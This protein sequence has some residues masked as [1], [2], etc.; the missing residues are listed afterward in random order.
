MPTP[1]DIARLQAAGRVVLGGAL[2]VAPR[3][4][5]SAWLGPRDAHR[6]TTAVVASAMGARDLGIG[7]GTA[8]AV[9]AGFGARP[10][11]IAGIL[12]DVADMVATLR[13]RDD[14]PAIGV[15]GIAALAGGSAALGVWLHRE[16]D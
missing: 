4:T 2:A 13:A 5:A 6:T 14:L 16:L 15:A 9:Q 1:R 3:R 11:L 12:G 8:R 7:I 10:W